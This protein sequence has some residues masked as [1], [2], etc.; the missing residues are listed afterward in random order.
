MPFFFIEL[1]N[2]RSLLTS[3]KID[4]ELQVVCH[5]KVLGVMNMAPPHL[6]GEIQL[7]TLADY[8][9]SGIV[10]LLD[11]MTEIAT[12]NLTRIQVQLVVDRA[13]ILEF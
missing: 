8:M 10:A 1:V 9:E 3:S 11:G 2:L 5:C 4:K 7:L 13:F 12:R 6:L